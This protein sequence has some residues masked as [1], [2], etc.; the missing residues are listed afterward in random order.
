[1]ADMLEL[2]AVEARAALDAREISAVELTSAYI[3]ADVSSPFGSTFGD[4][5]SLQSRIPQVCI[6]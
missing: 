6:A 5:G 3:A 2:G 1:M 4:G